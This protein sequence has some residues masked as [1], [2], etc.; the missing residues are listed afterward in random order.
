[1]RSDRIVSLTIVTL[2]LLSIFIVNTA[3]ADETVDNLVD[4]TFNIELVTATEFK[5][6]VYMDVI[7][8][9]AFRTTYDNSAIQ[10][11]V[12]SNDDDDKESLGVIKNYLHNSLLNQIRG[13]FENANVDELQSKPVYENNQFTE[14]YNVN[15]TSAYLGVDE[16]VN[17]HDFINGVLD[18]GAYVNYSL[19]LQA[20]T[21]WNNTYLI[22]FGDNLNYKRTTGEL[23]GD[24]IR[25]IVLNWNGETPDK[26]A[27]LQLKMDDPTTSSQT[28]EDIFLEFILDSANVEST[29]LTTN[30]IVKT[31][32]IRPY[33]VVPDFISNLDFVPADGIRLFVSNGFMLW[34]ETYEVNIKPLEEKIKTTIEGSS[35]NQTLDILFIWDNATTSG[36]PTPFEISNMD[37]EPSII[38]ILSDDNINLK[39]CDITSKAFFG[40]INSGADANITR[41]DI[42]FGDDLSNIGHN[43]SVMFYLPN[44]LYLENENIY[45]WNESDLI[46]GIFDSDI[47]PRYF[48]EEKDTV[49]EIE[50][51]T[52]D[53][54]LLSFFTGETELTFGLKMT[55]T[56]NYNI[57]NLPEQFTLPEKVAINYLN[58]DALRLCVKEKVF[59][60]DSISDFLKDEKNLF[61]DTL[62]QV[63]SGLE[64]SANVNR[65]IFDESI[66][67]WDGNISDMGSDT[68]V[69]TSSYSHSTHPIS[70]DLSFIP[71]GFD[72][73][74]KTF[75]F[76]GLPNQDV[77]YKVI[78]PHGISV[79]L[80]DSTF[81]T[82]RKEMEDGRHFIEI[83]F[84]ASESDLTVS[85]DCKMTASA[86]FVIG[87]F[88]PCIIC[89]VIAIILMI[90]IYFIRRKRRGRKKTITAVDEEETGYE[91]EDYY[92]PPPPGGK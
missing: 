11:L 63:I 5:I 47:A 40:L 76:T 18:M 48:D 45:T 80:N 33:N 68:P 37:D 6:N 28:A 9:V 20:K 43:Y 71:P 60:E 39:I 65:D 15:I 12:T 89:F 70:F 13:S 91:G 2:I 69:K 84:N 42:N 74:A 21:G 62:K 56:R 66:N 51:K 1:M 92:V 4:A 29:T 8:A 17:V 36:C 23:F 46:S 27:E 52:S 50:V 73:P 72:I 24:K 54:N 55:E 90:L 22:E 53:L 86:L 34:N 38:A 78:F 82:E 49:I 7:R 25:W 19:N 61:E 41:E 35:F 67:S 16:I 32:D 83:S 85:V 30:V 14:E 26:I 57:T 58:S 44:N 31:V 10:N 77:K 87:V 81:K 88:M 59:S 79:T 64:V 75:N 3:S